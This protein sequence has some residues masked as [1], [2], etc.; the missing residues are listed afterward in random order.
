MVGRV[1]HHD[2]IM[3]H[4]RRRRTSVPHAARCQIFVRS[5]NIC[6]F[7]KEGLRQTLQRAINFNFSLTQIKKTN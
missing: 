2:T 7:P 4:V 1:Q 6:F 3:P 5:Y